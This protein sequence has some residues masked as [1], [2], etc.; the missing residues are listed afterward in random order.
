MSLIDDVRAWELNYIGARYLL[1]LIE[2]VE[3]ISEE[4]GIFENGL[5]NIMVIF[6]QHKASAR[7]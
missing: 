5:P 6:L 3:A 2:K 4:Y 7:R 1:Q